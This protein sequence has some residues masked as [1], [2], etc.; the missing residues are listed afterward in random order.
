MGGFEFTACSS[1]ISNLK[2][3]HERDLCSLVLEE[4]N[5]SK[6][7]SYSVSISVLIIS[8]TTFRDC[9]MHIFSDLSQNSR[10]MM[11]L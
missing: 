4:S 6:S 7:D 8:H 9:R 5:K 2:E 11:N 10:I 1:K 3:F